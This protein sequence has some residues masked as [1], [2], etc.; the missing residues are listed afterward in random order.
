MLNVWYYQIE[1]NFTSVHV[2]SENDV[3]G[4]LLTNSC[5]ESFMLTVFEPLWNAIHGV[6]L[7][8]YDYVYNT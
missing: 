4:G 6:Y 8:F 2:W 1:L 3:L 7:G 5:N